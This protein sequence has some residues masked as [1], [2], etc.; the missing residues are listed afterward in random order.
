MQKEVLLVF[1][2][3]LLVPVSSASIN[4]EL[5]KITNYAEDFEAG[6]INYAQLVL[7]SSA[8][9]ERINEE[10]GSSSEFGG[11][12]KQEQLEP[13]LGKPSE[14]TKWIWVED[15]MQEKKLDSP[16]PVWRK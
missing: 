7:Y 5:Q 9:K 13:I 10:L 11:I 8:S 16:L 4:D 3:L 15:D 6:N 14:Q 2:L 12:V 1:L